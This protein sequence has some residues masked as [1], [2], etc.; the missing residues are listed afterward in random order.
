MVVIKCKES[1]QHPTRSL[2]LRLLYSSLFSSAYG[3]RSSTP[4]TDSIPAGQCR[5][6][7]KNVTF[8]R[9][10][11]ATSGF[12]F[13]SFGKS[14]DHGLNIGGREGGG[15]DG[16]GET[17]VTEICRA[18]RWT[19]YVQ[20]PVIQRFGFRDHSIV[21]VNSDSGA[22]RTRGHTTHRA[23]SSS[24]VSFSSAHDHRTSE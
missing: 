10:S 20:D 12:F 9:D 6:R 15:D 22:L 17:D 4:I 14:I 2:S 13:I 18:P 5:I 11:L 23:C 21:L 3:W 8:L 7:K 1:L 24:L 16:S 19:S